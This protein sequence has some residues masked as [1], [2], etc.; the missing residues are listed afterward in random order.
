MKGIIYKV[1]N[2]ENGQVYI[3]ATMGPLKQRCLD[4]TE[5][6]NRGETNKFHQAINTYGPEA[7]EW[8]QIDTANSIDDLA[9]KEKQYIFEYKSKEEGYNSD[10]G[11]GFKKTVY[12][13][14]LVTGKLIDSFKCLEDAAN[15]I[16]SCKKHISRACLSVNNVFRG[17]FWSYVYKEPFKPEKDSRKREVLQF[18]L[19]GNLLA[20]YVSV[21]EA[22]RI[23]GISKTCISRCCRG[24][25]EQTGGYIWKYA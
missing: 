16:D 9:L 11:G 2:K 7:F 22:S 23:T 12:Q 6:S 5:R 10:I 1:L 24:E 15:A 8:T 25:R 14:D 19:D 21:S 17:Y 20:N 3:G 18:N 4:H 13:Y